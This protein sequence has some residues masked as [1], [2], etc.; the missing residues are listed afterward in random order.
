MIREGAI[1]FSGRF[2]R[3]R[4][5]ELLP[6][7]RPDLPLMI[8]SNGPRM[9]RIALPHV[10]M[11][12]SWHTWFDNT[13][14]GLGPLLAE[15]DAACADV[16]RDPAEVERTAA[17]LLQFERG[18]GRIAGSTDRPPVTPITGSAAEMAETLA[19]FGEAGITHLQVV[20]DPVDARSVEDLAEVVALVGE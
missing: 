16:G 15:V 7:A 11:W 1:D 14:E 17:V 12:N 8:G 9:L 3:H 20:L 5:L 6:G 2:Y 10:E 4:D 18:T 19:R 13:P